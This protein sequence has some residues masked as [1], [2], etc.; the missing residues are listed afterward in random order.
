MSAIYLH[1]RRQVIRSAL[2]LQIC[3]SIG[4]RYASISRA[5]LEVALN[6]PQI[7]LAA[8][9]CMLCRTLSVFF[10]YVLPLVLAFNQIE[11]AYII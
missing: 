7:L 9:A 10:V 5:A 4:K 2:Y 3:C 11:H 1:E 6:T 8:L